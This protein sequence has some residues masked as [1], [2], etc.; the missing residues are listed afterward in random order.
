MRE[1]PGAIR[2]SLLVRD[3]AD[4][5]YAAVQLRFGARW[6]STRHAGQVQ[7]LLRHISGR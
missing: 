3:T 6:R 4:L 5:A 2:V 7:A 1:F